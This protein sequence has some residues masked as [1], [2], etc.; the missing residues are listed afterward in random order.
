MLNPSKCVA[1]TMEC[2]SYKINYGHLCWL[3]TDVQTEMQ[4][5]QVQ[6]DCP[7]SKAMGHRNFISFKNWTERDMCALWLIAREVTPG[8]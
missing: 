4:I 8:V 6:L 5:L 1:A 2:L 7:A 3:I